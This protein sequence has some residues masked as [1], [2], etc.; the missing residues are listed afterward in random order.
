[1]LRYKNKFI[2]V[3]IHKQGSG[4]C[5][6]FVFSQQMLYHYKIAVSSYLEI[7]RVALYNVNRLIIEGAYLRS[8]GYYLFLLLSKIVFHIYKMHE[9][10]AV[11]S[12]SAEQLSSVR[13]I[14]YYFPLLE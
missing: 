5:V 6:L 13:N 7:D 10:E 14:L 11:G 9:P 2:R 1:M 12:L 3:F 4:S 8:A